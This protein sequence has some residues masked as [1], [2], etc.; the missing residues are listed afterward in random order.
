MPDNPDLIAKLVGRWQKVSTS[1]VA[2]VFPDSLDINARGRFVGTNHPGARIHPI[3]DIGKVH[4]VG[5]ERVRMPHAND[6][7]VEYEVSAA[8]SDLTFVTPQQVKI[9]YRRV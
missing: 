6:Q 2:S 4:A 3:W 5:P 1:D 9:R 8:E 7:E